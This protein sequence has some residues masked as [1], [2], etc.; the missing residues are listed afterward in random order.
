M[1]ETVAHARERPARRHRGHWYPHCRI[2]INARVRAQ[3]EIANGGRICGT[4]SERSI[5]RDSTNRSAPTSPLLIEEASER[6][7]IALS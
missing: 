2:N 4:N 3:G 5:E 1:A 6:A 7:E